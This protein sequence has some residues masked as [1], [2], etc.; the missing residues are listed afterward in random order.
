MLPGRVAGCSRRYKRTLVAPLNWRK[1]N[2]KIDGRQYTV[3]FRDALQAAKDEVMRAQPE[4]LYWGPSLSTEHDA[5]SMRASTDA[6]TTALDTVLRNAWDGEMYK[7]PNEYIDGTL[8]PGTRVLG[9]KCTPTRL[10]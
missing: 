1:V 6:S 3:F 5:G 7:R 2:L 4:D 9:S 10:Y 8:H